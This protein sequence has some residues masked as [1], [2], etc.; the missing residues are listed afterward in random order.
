MDPIDKES[1]IVQPARITPNNPRKRRARLKSSLELSHKRRNTTSSSSRKSMSG[2]GYTPEHIV[3]NMDITSGLNNLPQDNGD[4]DDDDD[5]GI[6]IHNE[7]CLRNTNQ[8]DVSLNSIAGS[9]R[10]NGLSNLSQDD[11][12]S[13]DDTGAGIL[14]ETC[15]RNTDHLDVSLNPRAESENN[16]GNINN[17]TTGD[18]MDDPKDHDIVDN[19]NPNNPVLLQNYYWGEHGLIQELNLRLSAGKV[20]LSKPKMEQFWRKKRWMI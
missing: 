10:N 14:N 18:N 15:L 13:D 1:L 19:P 9:D 16:H 3:Q 11:V 7:T 4:G 8:L 5:I 2:F 12:D 6:G 20:G 17:I